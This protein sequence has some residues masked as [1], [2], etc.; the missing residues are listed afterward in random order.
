MTAHFNQR[1]YRRYVTMGDNPWD[2]GACVGVCAPY[3][4]NAR[5]DQVFFY[6]EPPYFYG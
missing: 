2:R 5:V 6:V 3:P 4:S 1:R